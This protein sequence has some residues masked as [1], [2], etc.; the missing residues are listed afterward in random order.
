MSGSAL[1]AS[2]VW[3]VVNLAPPAVGG[4]HLPASWLWHEPTGIKATEHLG[5]QLTHLFFKKRRLGCSLLVVP[6]LLLAATLFP[7]E[8]V[9][10]LTYRRLTALALSKQATPELNSERLSAPTQ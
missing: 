8:A 7:A 9:Q 1:D 3:F 6:K 5:L 10:L 4:C 2:N